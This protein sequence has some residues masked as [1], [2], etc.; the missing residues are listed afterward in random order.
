MVFRRCLLLLFSLFCFSARSQTIKGIVTDGISG[1]SL[2]NVTVANIA[3][4]N[5]AVT[6]EH[7]RYIITG[8]RGDVIVFTYV[9]YRTVHVAAPEHT[10]TAM[11]IIMFEQTVQLKEFTLHAYD[12]NAYQ[13][14]S[15]KRNEGTGKSIGTELNKVGMS[16]EFNNG[17]GVNGSISAL[18]G[19]ISGKTKKMKHLRNQFND[20]EQQ[21][22]IDLR[23][24]PEMVATLTKFTGD[25]VGVFMNAYP[26][27]YDF[28]RAATDLELKMWVRYN[29]RQYRSMLKDTLQRNT[30]AKP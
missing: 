26:M 1:A 3:T 5:V 24:T 14:D 4:R 12:Y 7:G 16:L 10:D 15:A 17:I 27:P 25:S 9:G 11:N 22:F 30:P 28:A 19:A 2:T 20:F 29:Y 21:R 23:Y 18:A 8:S 6:D 13:I